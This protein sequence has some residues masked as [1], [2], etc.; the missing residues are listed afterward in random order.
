MRSK[1]LF[2]YPSDHVLGIV[3]SEEAK[4]TVKTEAEARRQIIRLFQLYK[5][6]LVVSGACHL[7][8]IDIWAIQEARNFKIPTEQYPPDKL[9]W[10]YYKKRNI[11]I[12]KAST[13]VVCITVAKLPPDYK[14]MR[15]PF[16]YHCGTSSHVKSGG[17]W[18][19]K[20]ARDKLDKTA[21]TLTVGN[22]K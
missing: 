9:S 15:F 10:Q 20:Y 5:P 6:R 22:K 11:Q 19:T 13:I 17:C 12:A 3:G 8:G 7:G 14:G 21:F 1:P 18:T 2:K 4:F 16:C